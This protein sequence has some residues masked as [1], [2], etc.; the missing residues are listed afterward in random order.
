MAVC[1]ADSLGLSASDRMLPVVP[2]FHPLVEARLIDDAGEEVA[3]A[4]DVIK[5]GGECISSVELENELMAHPDVEEAAV[6]AMPDARWSERPLAC[7]VCR[8]DARP[9]PEALRDHLS[10]R[11]AKSCASGWPAESSMW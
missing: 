8:G 2:M 3:R 5:S 6:V 9:A 11:V 10:E 1:M 7:I 4:K